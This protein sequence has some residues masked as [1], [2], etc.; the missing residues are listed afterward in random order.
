MQHSHQERVGRSHADRPRSQ[1]PATRRQNDRKSTLAMQLD[2]TQSAGR[3]IKL[4]TNAYNI[5]TANKNFIIHEYELSIEPS[6][7]CKDL[8]PK[9][10]S[11]T[12]VSRSLRQLIMTDL[13]PNLIGS[14]SSLG[15]VVIGL[16]LEAIYSTRP[17]FQQNTNQA[18][19]SR[20][21]HDR[22]EFRFTNI[23]VIT[24]LISHLRVDIVIKFNR[25]LS[26]SPNCYSGS[27]QSAIMH[28]QLMMKMPKYGAVYYPL[29]DD[30]RQSMTRLD[31]ISRHFMGIS[32]SGARKSAENQSLVVIN[33][34]HSYI[35]HSYPLINL[36]ASFLAERPVEEIDSQRILQN[37]PRLT[38][39]RRKD[40]W[41]ASFCS[42]LNGFKCRA[43]NPDGSETNLRFDLTGES[44]SELFINDS[45]PLLDYYAR[46][47]VQINYPNLPCLKSRSLNHPFYPMETCNLLPG[48]KVPMFRLSTAARNHLVLMHKPHPNVTNSTSSKAR[49]DVMTINKAQFNSFGVRLSNHP[50]E[51]FGRTLRKPLLQYRNQMIDPTR[52][53]WESGIFYQSIDL[54][55][56]WCV[57]DTVGLTNSDVLL[58][59]LVQFSEY[60]KKFGLQIGPPFRQ[61]KPKQEIL[62]QQNSI[63]RLIAT[64]SRAT[65]RD[66]RF[67]MFII[68]SNSTQLN[69]MIH[70]AFDDHPKVT[71][72]CVRS[73]SVL[74]QRQRRSIYRT[75]VHKLNARLGGTNYTY[76]S[77]TLSH[78]S[79]D[80]SELMVVGLDVT[81]PD[82]ELNGV[83]I[84]GC[85]Y[86][87]CKDLFRHKSLVW[88][89]AARKEI[90]TK[91]DSLVNRLLT[92]YANE[93]RGRIPKQIIIYRDGV[94]NEEFDRVRVHEIT[95]AQQVIEE[96]CRN[97][98]Q[99]KPNLSYIIAQKRHTMRFF[100]RSND[101]GVQNPPGG[102][103][104]DHGVV[105]QD[106][107]EFYLYSNTSP[108][109]TARPLH[110]H[111]LLNGLGLDNLQKLTYYLCFNF[112][113]CSSSLSMP[114][115]LRY[116]HN[117]AYDARNRVIASK[118]FSENKF[119]TTKFFC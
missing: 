64:C 57:I 83:S 1:R 111:V 118:E 77:E 11:R 74:N 58:S 21:S 52:D 115:S 104:I 105:T 91:M 6:P 87:Y 119:Y 73:D 41:L 23:N 95:K 56:N 47:G 76:N 90:I 78:L 54:I 55:D 60:S 29:N 28:H 24:D 19:S 27:L 14:R 15:G 46:M 10:L 71:A 50:V 7:G 116:A 42:I 33:C 25:T 88:P 13:I 2:E 36:L 69:R 66:L 67:I 26:I 53:Y 9:V 43:I 101:G 12:Y 110:Y 84:V 31:L 81:H 75:L 99:I 97:N 49:D 82:N 17:L 4:V 63:E 37:I 48:Q 40:D 86:T 51:T 113:K 98:R 32:I 34:S 18:Q 108:Q 102:T 114:S 65:K 85:A 38:T 30:P 8:P 70:L 16:V 44:A 39:T 80:P 45:T 92:E 103:L 79:I 100:Q 93:N 89:Q 20:S 96:V 59:F 106:E 62:D 72:T 112:G 3:E 109:A 61:S 117:A 22:D 94:S 68:D 35:T 107:R 5:I